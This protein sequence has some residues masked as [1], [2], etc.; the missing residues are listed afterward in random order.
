MLQHLSSLTDLST[1]WL[2]IWLADRPT[3]RPTDWLTYWLIPSDKHKSINAKAM[4]LISSLFNVASSWD[5]PFGQLLQLQCLHH[6]S[7]KAYIVFH[8]FLYYRIG[9]DLQ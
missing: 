6:G 8:S 5:V 2:T 4:G 7:P 9:D 1:N 3:D